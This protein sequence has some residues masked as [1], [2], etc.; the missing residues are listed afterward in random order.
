MY[1]ASVS[2]PYFHDVYD[3]C[4]DFEIPIEG[5]HTET[6][7]GVYEA[8]LTYTSALRMADNAVLF[9]LTAKALGYKYG[10][11]P[12]FMAKP[13]N[14]LPG[15]SGHIHVSLRGKDNK[16]L[17]ATHYGKKRPESK[18]EDLQ[19]VSQEMGQS[20]SRAGLAS[21]SDCDLL[22]EWF[23]AGV[24]EGLPDIMPLL[25]PTVNG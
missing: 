21:F 19:Y 7:P 23:L 20:S 13:H 22:V 18:W 4:A 6:G 11:M 2:G 12:T 17:F 25:V 16:N 14:G 24:L 10:I 15:C 5:L 1:Y 3:T 9:K 8:A